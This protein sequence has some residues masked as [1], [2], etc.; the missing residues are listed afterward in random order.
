MTLA[1]RGDLSAYSKHGGGDYSTHAIQDFLWPGR[2]AAS[3]LRRPA[4]PA[5]A[6]SQAR[7]L[8]RLVGTL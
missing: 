5:T 2:S 6:L 3:L 7:W 4:L 1:P 8:Q